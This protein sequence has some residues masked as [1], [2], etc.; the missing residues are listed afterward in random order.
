MIVEKPMHYDQYKNYDAKELV[1]IIH[2]KYLEKWILRSPSQ[3]LWVHQR[4]KL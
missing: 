3:W 4:W 1:E 2:K